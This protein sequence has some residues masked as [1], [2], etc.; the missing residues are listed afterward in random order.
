MQHVLAAPP[1]WA[2]PR[3]QPHSSLPRLRMLLL[4]APLCCTG[5]LLWQALRALSAGALYPYSIACW[6]LQAWAL[7][8]AS[9]Q[10]LALWRRAARSE[11]VL[12]Q[13]LPE[14]QFPAMEVLLLCRLEVVEVVEA[15]AVAV[16]NMNYPGAKL[17]LRLVDSCGRRDLY[18]LSRRLQ[19]QCK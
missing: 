16:L 8:L 4:A 3:L 13:L 19:F 17:V 14:P 10:L 18:R 1:A 9:L 11:L 5:A 7:L 15:A 2:R 6:L 12:S